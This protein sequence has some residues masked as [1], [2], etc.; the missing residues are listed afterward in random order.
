MEIANNSSTSAYFECKPANPEST[1]PNQ[2]FYLALT[3]RAT[4]AFQNDPQAGKH[5]A[6]D[7]TCAPQPAGLIQ[8]AH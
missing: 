7:S 6:Q 8:L 3:L 4:V 5:S 1:A 2:L